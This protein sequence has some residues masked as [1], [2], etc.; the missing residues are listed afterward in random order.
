MAFHTGYCASCG[1]DEG[2]HEHLNRPGFSGDQ[3]S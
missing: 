2:L 3:N 1:F